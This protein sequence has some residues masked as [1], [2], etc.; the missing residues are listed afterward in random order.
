MSRLNELKLFDTALPE[1]S[2]I[3]G[4]SGH[5]GE[6]RKAIRERVAPFCD[7]VFTDTMGN[8][9]AHKKKEGRPRVA[10]TAHMDEVGMIVRRIR[11][12][13]ELE[14]AQAGLDPR[15]LPARRVTVGRDVPGV[16]GMKAIHLQSD[17]EYEN[18]P[19]HKE[20]TVDI[21]AKDKADAEKYVKIGDPICFTTKFEEFGDG[22][23]TGKAL[24]DRVGCA[25]VIELLKEDYDFDLYA[26]FTVQEEAGIRGAEL[27]ADHVL[28]DIVINF[29][30]TTANDIPSAKG[31]DRVCEVGR[32]P[33]LTFMDR[34]TV[35]LPRVFDALRRA[36][37]ENGIPFQLRRGVNGR[38][39][40]GA[41]H[42]DL[43]G[44]LA[45]GISVPCRYIHS[46]NSVASQE[47]MKNM[48]LLADAFLKGNYIDEIL[49]DK[50][51]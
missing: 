37:K 36:A 39:D 35:V 23:M 33:A 1:L 51:Q 22:L 29:E 15:V 42:R 3:N 2:N 40:M 50:P 5:E 21:G 49:E 47:D 28:P 6:V 16:I 20:L 9:Y 32:G 45:C 41:V 27:V 13:G 31:H 14:Y 18:A 17:E 38:T 48:I 19:K 26:A 46:A 43:A 7:E 12:D 44:C 34:G 30:G 8:L 25:A 10:L 4:V 24:D 11:D